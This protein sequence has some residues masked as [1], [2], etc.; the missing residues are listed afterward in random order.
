MQGSRHST[1]DIGQDDL[2]AQPI[3]LSLRSNIL[4]YELPGLGSEIPGQFLLIDLVTGQHFGLSSEQAAIIRTLQILQESVSFKDVSEACSQ[5]FGITVSCSSIHSLLKDLDDLALIKRNDLSREKIVAKQLKTRRAILERLQCDQLSSMIHWMKDSLEFYKHKLADHPARISRLENVLDLPITTREDVR[6]NL[7]KLLPAGLNR[8][9]NINWRSTSGTTSERM[10][11][12]HVG[13]YLQEVT[14]RVL[15]L[16][17]CFVVETLG[18]PMCVL[19]TPVCS[20]LECHMDMD[21]PYERRLRYGRALFLNSVMNPV[22]FPEEKLEQIVGEIQKHQPRYLYCNASYAASLALYILRKQPKLPRLKTVLTSFEVTS[23]IHKRLLLQAFGCPSFE[24]YGLTEVSQA[25]MQ[26]EDGQMYV[27]HDTHIF[28]I[29]DRDRRPVHPGEVGRLY[30]TSL[31]KYSVPLLRYQTTDL[32]RAAS[33]PST[34]RAEF[35]FQRIEGRIGDLVSKPDGQ[36]LT[37]RMVDDAVSRCESGIGW[38]SLVQKS[39]NSY[40]LYL[41]PTPEYSKRAERQLSSLLAELLGPEAGMSIEP[42]KEIRPGSS[43]KFRLC[44]QEE[45][46]DSLQNQF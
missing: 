11:T 28:E 21:V 16:N 7:H 32:A 5:K 31:R 37:P 44:Y 19:T 33:E 14:Q 45:P 13:D 2:A 41:V 18:S 10:Q 12:V 27:P 23:K 42:V 43:G 20:G 24:I 40:R 34:T 38:Y 39:E 3:Q 4:L 8:Y 17:P 36:F 6:Q 30:I 25:A 22:Q 1:I 15:H 46:Q 9:S 26:C 35:C 29:L